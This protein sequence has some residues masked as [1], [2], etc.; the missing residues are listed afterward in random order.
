MGTVVCGPHCGGCGQALSLA[1]PPVSISVCALVVRWFGLRTLDV[2]K[3]IKNPQR[4][5]V[6]VGCI[7]CYL[8]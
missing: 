4:T 2:M 5:V 8:L 6:Y 7:Y 3:M 1:E